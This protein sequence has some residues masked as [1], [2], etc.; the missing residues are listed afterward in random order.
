MIRRF[1]NRIRR[2]EPSAPVSIQQIGI[3]PRGAP[4]NRNVSNMVVARRRAANKRARAS[5]KRNRR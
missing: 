4:G 5:R 3:A 1:I 2:T